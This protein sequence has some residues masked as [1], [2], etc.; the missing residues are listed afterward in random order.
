MSVKRDEQR[1]LRP[2]DTLA[3]HR[4]YRAWLE[5]WLAEPFGGETIVVTHHA[6]VPE[7]LVQPIDPLGPA[8]G[9]DFRHVIVNYQLRAWYCG[10]THIRYNCQVGRTDVICFSLSYPAEV[11]RRWCRRLS[12]QGTGHLRL[13]QDTGPAASQRAVFALEVLFADDLHLEHVNIVHS[14]PNRDP[15][16]LSPG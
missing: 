5:A 1:V 2:E 16:C 6:P 13:R 15:E 10:H 9:S 7:G 14:R 11:P 8:F 12:E 4:D 3:A